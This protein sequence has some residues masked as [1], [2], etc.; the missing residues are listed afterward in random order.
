VLIALQ[1]V[2]IILNGLFAAAE[3][4]VIKIDSNRLVKLTRSGDKRAKKLEALIDQPSGFLATIQVGITL[5]SLLSAAVAT[6]NFSG[7]LEKGLINMGINISEPLITTVSVFL[8]TIILTYFTV[9]LGELVPKRIGMK[10]AEKI[11][12]SMAGT[13]LVLSKIFTPVVWLFTVST[14]GILKLIGINPISQEEKNAEEEIRLILDV[15]RIQGTIL[16]TEHEMIQNVFEFNDI[17]V[18]E[19]MTPRKEVSFLEINESENQ[20]RATILKTH[21]SIYPVCAGANDRVEGVLYVK[22]YFNHERESRKNTLKHAMRPAYF[23]PEDMRADILF[24]NMQKAKT[25]FAVVQDQ[26]K[27]MSGIITINDLLE[28]IVGEIDDDA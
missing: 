11:A 9:L 15:G 13:L 27:K 17:A 20:W 4:A 22:D 24:Q 21:H 3:I 6:E 16:S 10:S 19:I 1:F 14:N 12:L 25:Y 2:F 7:R 28:Q 23:I 18:G 5:I 8:I 26:H